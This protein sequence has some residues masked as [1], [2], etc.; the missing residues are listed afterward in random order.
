M[1]QTGSLDKAG[2]PKVGLYEF[3]WINC[4]R[5]RLPRLAG[6]IVEKLSPL[7]IGAKYFNSSNLK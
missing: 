4:S 7:L 6:G 5:N 1:H 2:A 3:G